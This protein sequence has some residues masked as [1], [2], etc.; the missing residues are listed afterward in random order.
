MPALPEQFREGSAKSI[1]FCLT[2]NCNFACKYCY[3]VN[4]DHKK[5]LTKEQALK[6]IDFVFDN[7]NLFQE[8]SVIWEFIGGEPLLEVELMDYMCDVLKL[9]MW[10]RRPD[11]MENHMFNLATN[12]SLYHKPNVRRFIEKNRERLSL[13]FSIDGN[14]ILHDGARVYPDGRGT[15][16]DVVKNIDLYKSDFGTRS[17]TKST[18]ARESLPHIF[19]SVKYLF[20]L[21]LIV[22]MNTVFEDCWLPG[23]DT[24]FY[25][26]LVKLADWMIES[27]KWK[28]NY[29]SLFDFRF[30]DN[31]LKLSNN[32]WCGSGK[33][34]HISTD[35]KF[36]PCTRLA[37]YSMQ[38][39]KEGFEIG[40]IVNGYNYE[41]VSAFLNLTKVDQSCSTC[42]N[43][44]AESGCAWCTG[45]N[46]DKYGSIF[47]RATAICS[48]HKARVLANQ[49]YYGKLE[50][51][52]GDSADKR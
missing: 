8:D 29:V 42:M 19:D 36:Y 14:K 28:T 32:N 20:S 11:W 6:N 23:D 48:M 47:K 41:K 43:C 7:P 3:L 40:D 21:D 9:K 39:R 35:G 34:L 26:Q 5:K 17:S 44:E 45:W 52:Y 31:S 16:E 30:V 22:Y 4:F 50:K 18:L 13:G 51:L 24:L 49:Y 25:D 37:P 27:G 10:E 2:E 46:Y 38:Y 12:G 1:T 15:F 33:M